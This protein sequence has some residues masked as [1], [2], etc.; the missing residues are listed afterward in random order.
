MKRV[1]VT[2]FPPFP[3][4]PVNPS[5]QIVEQI[6]SGAVAI[7]GVQLA[8]ELLP[9]EYVGIETE[10]F[11]CLRDHDPDLWLAFGVGRGVCDFRLESVGRNLDNAEHPDNA[12]EVR[13]GVPI[14]AGGP[15]ELFS[16]HDLKSLQRLLTRQG[17][18]AAV[19]QDA[20]RY[21]CN[22]LQYFALYHLPSFRKKCQFLF[23]H[24]APDE[25][26][27]PLQ[28]LL[29]ALQTMVDGFHNCDEQGR[30]SPPEEFV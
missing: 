9:V 22:H 2:G 23:T 12:G 8:A 27:L 17:F 1:L 13:L 4:R 25:S 3:G 26:G 24:L 11:R 29:L 19:S 10:F 18:S 30:G 16:P 5:Q 6:R 7:P 21:L 14:L 20:G 28:N 15:G